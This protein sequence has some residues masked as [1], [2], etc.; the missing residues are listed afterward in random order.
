MSD[1][2]CLENLIIHT[3]FSVILTSVNTTTIRL[4]T[5]TVMSQPAC[6]TAFIEEGVC[7]NDNDNECFILTY[8][9]RYDIHIAAM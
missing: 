5:P 4:P 1:M 9:L 6:T 8:E 7:N 2:K 3:W